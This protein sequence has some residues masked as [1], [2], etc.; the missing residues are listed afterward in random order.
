M[1]WQGVSLTVQD[2]LWMVIGATVG[3]M[4]PKLCTGRGLLPLTALPLT[5]GCHVETL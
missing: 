2:L 1:L 4:G 3:L 5:Q